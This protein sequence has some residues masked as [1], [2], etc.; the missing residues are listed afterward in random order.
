[1]MIRNLKIKK[2]VEMKSYVFFG[3]IGLTCTDKPKINPDEETDSITYILFHFN[4]EFICSGGSY[5]W[6]DKKQN[7]GLSKT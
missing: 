2:R 4:V 1:M 3:Q 5:N 7:S 6:Y